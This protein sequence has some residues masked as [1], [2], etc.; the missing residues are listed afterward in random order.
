MPGLWPV[1]LNTWV[2]APR[3]MRTHRDCRKGHTVREEGC[4]V[5]SS[6]IVTDAWSTTE[7][8]AVGVGFVSEVL[9]H[10]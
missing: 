5:H 2:S 7:G 6:I 8:G 3:H 4:I 10:G 1:Y 9:V